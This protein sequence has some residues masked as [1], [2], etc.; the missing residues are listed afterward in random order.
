MTKQPTKTD[1]L[2][3]GFEDISKRVRLTMVGRYTQYTDKDGGEHTL[4]FNE[5]QTKA[6]SYIL[7][8]VVKH[9]GAFLTCFANNKPILDNDFET[10]V[11]VCAMHTNALKR[12]DIKHVL[13]SAPLSFQR[14]QYCPGFPRFLNVDGATAEDRL[15]PRDRHELM[16]AL[17]PQSRLV[18]I[19]GV[20]Y[21]P[22]PPSSGCRAPFEH[23][24]EFRLQCLAQCALGQGVYHPVVPRNLV[25]AQQLTA[26]Q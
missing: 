6:V 7:S 22:T 9:N 17:M 13:E 11:D 16:H 4:N 20:P 8:H 5:A 21:T 2:P 25:A 26:V 19:A 1:N 12:P 3:A 10:T 14:Y 18:V 15:C 23:R 24:P